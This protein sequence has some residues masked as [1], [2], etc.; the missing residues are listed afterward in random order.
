MAHKEHSQLRTGEII[1]GCK[2]P[3]VCLQASY[4][5]NQLKYLRGHW[6]LGCHHGD[7]LHVWSVTEDILGDTTKAEIVTKQTK[8]VQIGPYSHSLTLCT[9]A[10]D[11]NET[12]NVARWTW[13]SF[14]TPLAHNHLF[15]YSFTYM[16]YIFVAIHQWDHTS[17]EILGFEGFFCSAGGFFGRGQGEACWFW[18]VVVLVCFLIF[19]AYSIYMLIIPTF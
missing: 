7:A 16:L 5:R 17:V 11:V 13:T 12:T 8:Y 15:T 9:C 10:G 6:A 14:L 4:V 1:T 19:I 3:F 2:E 18:F